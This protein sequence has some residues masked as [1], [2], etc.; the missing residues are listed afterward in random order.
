MTIGSKNFIVHQQFEGTDHD[1]A[2]IHLPKP[3]HSSVKILRLPD[4]EFP[5]EKHQGILAGQGA[6]DKEYIRVQ[7]KAIRYYSGEFVPLK[8]CRMYYRD[9]VGDAEICYKSPAG[10]QSMC[11]GDSGNIMVVKCGEDDVAVGIAS[12]A[13]KD[14]KSRVPQI[15]TSVR[16]FTKWI[17]MQ[18]HMKARK[19]ME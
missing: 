2:L 7:S 19:S 18:I 9:Y 15:F 11:E 3:V 4:L 16:E 5:V 17:L 10:Y 1:I 14:C 6:I 12:A 8:R 13:S